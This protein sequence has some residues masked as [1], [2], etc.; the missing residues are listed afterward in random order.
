M[1][2]LFVELLF[3]CIALTAVMGLGAD[4][5]LGKD[6]CGAARPPVAAGGACDR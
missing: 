5:V 1:L 2:V 4:L 3:A 6:R